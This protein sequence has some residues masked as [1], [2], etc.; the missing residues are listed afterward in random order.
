MHGKHINIDELFEYIS[1]GKEDEAKN[2]LHQ[3]YADL[4]QIDF[5]EA[6]H[7][8]DTKEKFKSLINVIA[9]SNATILD[10]THSPGLNIDQITALEGLKNSKISNINFGM[11]LNN[12]E[13]K[14]K[15]DELTRVL[16]VLKNVNSVH[17]ELCTKEH[18][19][20]LG[21]LL[22][23]NENIKCLGIGNNGSCLS[24]DKDAATA[25]NNALRISKVT[26]FTVTFGFQATKTDLEALGETLQG[27]NITR[28]DMHTDITP[29]NIPELI[30]L[31]SNNRKII[32]FTNTSRDLSEESKTAINNQLAINFGTSSLKN[33]ALM[34]LVQ[35]PKAALAPHKDL[36][37][38]KDGVIVEKQTGENAYPDPIN[39]DIERA[40]TFLGAPKPKA[41]WTA[42]VEEKSTS[43]CNHNGLV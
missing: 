23:N 39:N 42:D 10:F 4:T 12:T 16:K 32:S 11:S 21:N 35:N 40:R 5:N 29:K 33:L 18:F 14:E 34:T 17:F 25:L 15:I 24:Q 22:L 7:W 43:K 36:A 13:N 20:G 41:T 3:D 2:Y 6:L 30:N 1:E 26:T 37:Y 28:L 38:N 9:S 19:D 31:L 27:T 8:F